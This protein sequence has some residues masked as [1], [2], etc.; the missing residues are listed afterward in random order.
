MVG[1][2][3]GAIGA[4]AADPQADVVGQ[5]RHRLQQDVQSLALLQA[6]DEQD[7]RPLGVDGLGVGDG[8]DLDAVEQHPVVVTA[9]VAAH[10]LEGVLGDDDTA[11]DVLGPAH[12]QRL[13]HAVAGRAAGGVE[14]AHDRCR[15]H[16]QRGH[17]RA[18]HERLVDVEDVELLVVESPDRAQGGRR[19]RRQRGD[20]PVGRRRQAVAERGHEGLWRRPVARTEDADLV[21]LAAQ[22]AGEAEHLTL[23]APGHGQAVGA[24]HADAQRPEA[25][26]V[27][28]E[29]SPYP[30]SDC[31]PWT[32]STTRSATTSAC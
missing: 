18:G 13:E 10:E 29:R 4:V 25:G 3:A 27:R 24:D 7:R 21:A 28:H 1:P 20:R 11:A 22:L 5:C 17:R 9:E 2:Q 23:H 16:E 15:V 30:A 6:S 32:T 19:V 26:C 14:R 31:S 12:D 8:V